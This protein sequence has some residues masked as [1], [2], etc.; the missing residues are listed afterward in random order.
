MELAQRYPTAYDGI[1]ASAP[2]IHLASIATGIYVPQQHMNVLGEYPYPC[3]FDAIRTAAVDAC[4]K[5]DGVLDG[6]VGDVE[7]CQTAFDPFD[8]V[9]ESVDCPQAGDGVQV[10]ITL[11]AASVAN[12]SWTDG[13]NSLGQTQWFAFSPTTDLTGNYLGQLSTALTDCS[14]GDGCVGFPQPLGSEWMR[15][16]VG[17]DPDFDITGLTMDEFISM[18]HDT[19]VELA[20]SSSDDPNLSAFRDAGGKLV[21]FH[22]LVSIYDHS[23]DFYSI[24]GR[25]SM[26]ADRS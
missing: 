18:T 20:F 2:A 11:A 1:A 19:S 17:Q 23:V 5:L 24:S 21:A 9:G 3:E 4:D 15:L 12:S 25:T 8:L 7:G 14:G 22:G 10:P 16:F 13:K 26:T 6:V